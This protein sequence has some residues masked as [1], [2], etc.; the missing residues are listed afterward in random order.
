MIP[1]DTIEKIKDLDIVRVV[2]DEGLELKKVSSD[3]QACCPFHGEKTPSFVVSS[4]KGYYHCFGCGAHGGTINFV[5]QYLAMT[6]LEACGHLASKNGIEIEEEEPS[7]EERANR[8]RRDELFRA[9]KVAFEFYIESYKQSA[10]ARKY[11]KSRW[12]DE[13]INFWGVGYA[14]Q[15][16][17]LL[18]YLQEKKENIQT[19]VEA[20]VIKTSDNGGHFDTYIGRLMFPIRN[21]TGGITGFS[22]RLIVENK[23]K[24]RPKY[25]NTKGE[26]SEGVKTLFKKK[27]TLFGYFEA[28]RIAARRDVLNIVEGHPDVIRMSTVDQLNT[29]APMG[30][31][32]SVEQIGMIKRIVSKVIII[33]DQDTAGLNATIKNGENLTRA[34]LSVRVMTIPEKKGKDPDEYFKKKDSDYNLMLSSNTLDFIDFIYQHKTENSKTFSQNDRLEVIKYICDLLSSYDETLAKMYVDKLGK[35]EKQTKIWTETFYHIRNKKE[36]ESLKEQKQEQSDLFDKFG[37]YVQNNSY[38]GKGASS[39]NNIQW[40][41]FVINPIALIWDKN[42]AFRMF[43]IENINRERCILT[44]Q[45]DQVTTLDNFQKNIEA[46]GNYIIEAIVAKPQYTQLK[47]YLYEKTPTAREIEQLGWHKQGEFFAW[48]NG[49]FDGATFIEADKYGLVQ[50]KDRLF[51][52]PGASKENSDDTQ[53][54]VLQKKFV[55]VPTS[56][57]TMYD[58]ADQCVK[59]FGENAVIAICFYFTSLFA[60]IVKSVAGGLPILNMFGPPSTGKTQLAR[61]IVAPTQIGPKSFNIRT[62]TIAA[63]GDIVASVSNAVI[64]FDEYKDDINPKVI[65]FFKGLWDDT[66]RNKMSQEGKKKQITTAV[67]SAVVMTGQEMATADIAL[68]SR[69]V[70]LPFHGSTHTHEEGIRYEKF[71]LICNRGLCH[72]TQE[73]LTQRKKVKVG[74]R[75]VY[76]ETVAELQGLTQSVQD[77]I[78]KNWCAIIAPMKILEEQIKL[79]FSYKDVLAITAKLCQE[80]NEKVREN[81][82]LA[83]FWVTIGVLV[84]NSKVLMKA[85]YIIKPGTGGKTSK[86]DLEAGREYLYLRFDILVDA[87]ILHAKQVGSRFI[88]KASLKEYLSKSPEYKGYVSSIRFLQRASGGYLSETSAHTKTIPTSAWVF[89]Y[90]TIKKKYDVNLLVI[91]YDANA[92]HQVGEVQDDDKF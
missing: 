49:A 80:Q 45:Q 56:N 61:A 47:K 1:Q 54:Y 60:D 18:K 71:K 75:T 83:D 39:S 35:Q 57:T 89:D 11:A 70:L 3:Y 50:V 40:T 51:Y 43:E 92:N 37:F 6:F 42:N 33:G 34:G 24:K 22:G 76:D 36:V 41:N 31:D 8:F 84:S 73:V 28:Q 23:D 46:K 85:D 63:I 26:S 29:V 65:E 58:Y 25:L 55:Y 52:L 68:M 59:V 79:P 66:G 2:Q 27:E 17:G 9:N 48:G 69:V 67:D 88:P 30:T 21:R 90:T 10:P 82:E 81:D 86:G 77:R 14:P 38:F 87:Y 5:M 20:G 32:L 74:Y 12:N 53:T 44:L 91:E 64:H 78:L 16:N 7:P 19:F 4:A 72:L 15:E 13:T 62:T